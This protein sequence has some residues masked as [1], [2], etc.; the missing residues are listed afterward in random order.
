MR[1][2]NY[3]YIFNTMSGMAVKMN[4]P[5]IQIA[6]VCLVKSRLWARRIMG[7]SRSFSVCADIKKYKIPAYARDTIP[8]S[9]NT[10]DNSMTKP[11][12]KKHK[13]V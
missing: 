12:F 6:V 5:A 4:M 8:S 10:Y 11:H 1:C 13:A 3:D 9:K 7:F 2:S